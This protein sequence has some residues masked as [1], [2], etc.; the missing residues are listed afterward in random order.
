MA[1]IL[2]IQFKPSLGNKELNLKKI[3]HFLKKY[4]DKHLDLVVL[5]EFFSTGVAHESFINSP[6]DE[7]G[8]DTIKFIQKLAKEYNTNIIAGT[9]IEGEGN[10]A[11]NC[12]E[13]SEGAES[14]GVEKKLYNTSF[15]IN[16]SGEIACKYRK[17]HLFNYMG[18]TEGERITPGNKEV[19]V[20]LDFAKVGLGICF[21]I[22]YPLHFNK[23]IKMG[24]DIIVVPTAWII[25]NEI[26]NDID[27]RKNAQ[28]LWLAINKTRAYDNMVYIVSCNQTGRVDEYMSGLGTSVIVSPTS[29]IIA[30][31]KNDECALFADIDLDLVKFYRQIYPIAQI[32]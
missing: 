8:G 28:E 22:R 5:P 27:A 1:G 11:T 21:D 12:G 3:Q 7:N 13:I 15:I 19:V 2:N 32:D 23:L 10:N 4:K 16:R 18:G 25:P 24:A 6:E 20:D 31:A 17:I 30:N 14:S 26:Y 29:E 9:V